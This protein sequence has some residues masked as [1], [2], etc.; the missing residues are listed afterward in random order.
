MDACTMAT[1]DIGIRIYSIQ[2]AVVNAPKYAAKH[3]ASPF[4]FA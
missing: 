4:A 1:Y 2:L 3:A